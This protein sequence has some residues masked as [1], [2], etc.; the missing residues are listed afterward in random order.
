MSFYV[1]KKPNFK[2]LNKK[3]VFKNLEIKYYNQT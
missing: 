2:Y 1:L 3:Y